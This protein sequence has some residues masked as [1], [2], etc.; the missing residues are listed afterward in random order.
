MQ[1]QLRERARIA[2]YRGCAAEHGPS[3]RQGKRRLKQ[4]SMAST[5]AEEACRRICLVEQQ[6]GTERG[7]TQSDCVGDSGFMRLAGALGESEIGFRQQ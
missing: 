6:R 4:E 1:I 3:E 7:D 2:V 5:V